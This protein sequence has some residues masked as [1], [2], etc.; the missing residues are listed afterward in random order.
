MGG[1][2]PNRHMWGAIIMLPGI[3]DIRAALIAASAAITLAGCNASTM[4]RHDMEPTATIPASVVATAAQAA[5][6]TGAS[7]GGSEYRLG[8]GDKVRVVV[9]NEPALS[10]EFQV[11]DSGSVSVP[12]V[13]SQAAA[14]LTPRELE[15]QLTG[16]LKGGFV[17]DP[18]V[19]VE[20]S[21]YRPFYVIGEIEKPG[22]YQYRNGLSILAAA[23]ISG[24][25][26]YRASRSKVYIKRASD[27]FEREYPIGP[28]TK[29]LPGD[30]IR[31]PER[32]F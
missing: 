24:G 3:Q 12:L 23:A 25:F 19:S 20:V 7:G 30:V 26:T 31:V 6:A 17:R 8:T 13:G 2:A 4:A 10:G 28:Q 22:E 18:K 14:G 29:V 32:Y 5:P 16:R 1:Y 11:D 9:F 15:K 21:N 27:E